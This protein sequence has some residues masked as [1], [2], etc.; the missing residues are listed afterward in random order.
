MLCIAIPDGVTID[1]YEVFPTLGWRVYRLQRPRK[2]NL[3]PEWRVFNDI[4]KK[5][6][7]YIASRTMS[8]CLRIPT[9]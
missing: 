5:R 3:I 9:P 1:L 4:P 2:S 6:M 8:R 7:F